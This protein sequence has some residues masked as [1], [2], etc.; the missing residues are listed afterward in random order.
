MTGLIITGI[1][2]V[3]TGVEGIEILGIQMI[4]CNAQGF[5]EAL[6][7]DDLAGTQEL[8]GFADIRLL[9][10]TQ[11]IVV[12]G[13]G[14]L[15]RSHIFVQIGDDIPLYL[16]LTGIE[17]HA[18]RRLGPDTDGMIHVVIGET[19]FFDLLH[20]KVT[21]QLVNDGGDYLEMPEFFG[22]QRSIGNVPQRKFSSKSCVS[23]ALG[24]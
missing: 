13:T 11:D 19:A 7:V 17:G 3:E 23:W 1:T 9:N 21:G 24:T 16:E 22:S 20:G 12:G 18:A 14:F 6:V 2:A 15:L 10:Q 8:D 4:L 5:S